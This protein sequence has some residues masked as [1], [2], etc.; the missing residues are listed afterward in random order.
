MRQTI[1]AVLAML[2]LAWAIPARAAES[3]VATWT[4]RDHLGRDFIHEPVYLD[5]E[6]KEFR[7]ADLTLLGPDE[8]P[9]PFQWVAAADS[10]HGKPGALFIADVKARGSAAYRLVPGKPADQTDLT[11]QENDAAIEI[12]NAKM[13]LRVAR[14]PAALTNGPIGG[15]RLSSGKWVAGKG[16][17]TLPEAL[18]R[19]EAK[20]IA[21][22]PVFV[23]VESLYRAAEGAG[24]DR[25]WR[26]RF[27]LYAGEASVLV[28]EDFDNPA[29]SSY[30][31]DLGSGANWNRVN[32]ESAF[33]FT[34]KGGAGAETYPL[35]DKVTEADVVSLFPWELWSLGH[36][37]TWLALY[38]EQ[39]GDLLGIGTV[40]PTTWLERPGAKT[41]VMP[42]G[43]PGR[44]GWPACPG[45]GLA[46][47]NTSLTFKM[48]DRTLTL[49][50]QGWQRR[51]LIAAPEG[52]PVKID[53]LAEQIDAAALD[54]GSDDSRRLE[55]LDNV[56]DHPIV[57]PD[58]AEM[59]RLFNSALP[60][61]PRQV[62]KHGLVSLDRVA[63]MTLDWPERPVKHPRIFADEADVQRVR[64]KFAADPALAEQ[65]P[66]EPLTPYNMES[67]VPYALGT[68]DAATHKQLLGL[69]AAELQFGVARFA[70][71]HRRAA[72]MT[73][74]PRTGIGITVALAALDTVMNSKVVTPEQRADIRA[75]A[76]F[77]GYLL[78]DPNVFAPAYGFC[79]NA[80][81]TT[82]LRMALGFLA[83]FVP[84]HPD[85]P[86]WA[87]MA[88]DELED[89]I[90]TWSGEKGGWR[91]A[92]HYALCSL[93]MLTAYASALRRTAAETA[94][95]QATPGPAAP[96][97]DWA[98]HERL[99]LAFR[100]IARIQTPPDPRLDGARAMPAIGNTYTGERTSAPAWIATLWKEKDPAFAAEMQWW[101][102][103]SKDFE[104]LGIGGYY[105][106]LTGYR[107]TMF[108]PELKA[109][110]P[111]AGSELFPNCGAVLRAHFNT[112]Q[113]TYVHYIAGGLHEHYDY[114]EGSFIFWGR[115][116]PLCDDFGY[117]AAAPAFDHSRVDGNFGG[118]TVESFVATPAADF[119]HGRLGGWDRRLTLVKDADPNGPN[120]LVVNDVVSKEAGGTWR[121]WVL[122]D[123]ALIGED[124]RKAHQKML[125]DPGAFL[126][127]EAAVKVPGLFRATGRHGVD[128]AMYVARPAK[129]NA[130]SERAMRVSKAGGLNNGR[131]LVQYSLAFPM[132][133]DSSAMV[134]LFPVLPK[135][136]NPSFAAIADGQGVRISGK[137]WS[138]YVFDVGGNV[139][140]VLKADDVS[141]DGTRGL[142]QIRGDKAIATLT[143]PGTITYKGKSL[144]WDGKG[145]PG[146]TK[147]LG[148]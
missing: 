144:T 88:T 113:E 111:A 12:G 86:R 112:P 42:P 100:W 2:I 15:V 129:V 91:E 9:V 40:M 25:H 78:E 95:L 140:M 4:Y 6:T 109:V 136:K 37:S 137:G 41:L 72:P 29:G 117:Y 80:N 70:G 97:V 10:P 65:R 123:E 81:M 36:N 105:P 108:S 87:R 19:H 145:G 56:A 114:D 52:K 60:E 74:P 53:A 124:K 147:V 133:A 120:Y 75:Q 30:A 67:W 28:S 14:G 20:V 101:W 148:E 139:A 51:W 118:G 122:T 127:E 45:P 5:V 89:E 69:G 130:V 104:H 59:A 131:A 76:A 146:V 138:D 68:D 62:T 21:R 134:V 16:A 31:W 48:I 57:K 18:P 54:K 7:R 43:A 121:T 1:L 55:L 46:Q 26:L 126:D 73:D 141:F 50:L 47:W 84:D 103:Q 106:G 27:R 85:S 11:V 64:A 61:M 63:R 92:P 90:E 33:D 49:P 116:K 99:R 77:L 119:L 3:A 125:D 44:R 143:A 24:G 32:W 96:A 98:S 35:S 66:P 38:R 128:L 71:N 79:A 13:G 83:C 22:G 102:K 8:K 17:V 110:A 107:W 34:R 82:T 58:E 93:D 39:E 142:L 132:P 94:K 23:E 135:E 115:G